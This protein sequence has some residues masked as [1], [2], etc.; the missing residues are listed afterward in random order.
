MRL[1]V[2]GGRSDGCHGG[3]DNSEDVELHFDVWDYAWRDGILVELSW[4]MEKI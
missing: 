3:E 1:N 2:R 4:E